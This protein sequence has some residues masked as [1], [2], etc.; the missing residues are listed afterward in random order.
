MTQK[1]D[2]KLEF[3]RPFGPPIGR[4]QMPEKMIKALN[5]YVDEQLSTGRAARY[6]FGDRLVGNVKQEFKLQED[7]ISS[8]GL[9]EMVGAATK[10]WVKQSTNR[11]ISKFEI[12]DCWIVRQ[13][14]HEYNPTHFHNGHVSGVGYLMRPENF[15]PTVQ[16]SKK[17]NRNGQIQFIHGQRA[18]L[19]DPTM[20]FEPQIGDFF[21][22]P[23]YMMHTVYPFN[24]E[25]ERRSLSFNARIDDNIY[26]NYS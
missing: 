8:S 15:G 11:E 25:G 22:F 26:H 18:F 1:N 19:S 14:K 16:N 23:H 17:S 21:L 2:R 12:L 9:L 7:I 24:S 6:D 13:F 20:T 10:A 3:F 4:A 5:L